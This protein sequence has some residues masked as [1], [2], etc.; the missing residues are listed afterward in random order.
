M[1]Q[2]AAFLDV[3]PEIDAV[4]AEKGQT[5]PRPKYDNVA[6]KV[7]GADEVGDDGGNEDKAKKKNHEATSDEGDE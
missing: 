7:E 1:D 2:F 4:L 5:I 3:L 6:E